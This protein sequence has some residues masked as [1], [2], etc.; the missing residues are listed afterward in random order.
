[1]HGPK[2]V[3]IVFATMTVFLS[4]LPVLVSSYQF[5]LL[6]LSFRA[7][8][9]EDSSLH[10]P[11]VSILIPAWNEGAVIGATIDRLMRL[12]YPRDRLRVYVI[13][14]A[15]TD[16]T[17]HVAIAKSKL[18]PRNVFHIRR[19]A[20]GEGKAHT[21]NYGL[22]VLW[23]SAWTEAVLIMDADVIYTEDS[24]TKMARHLVDPE[25]GAVTAYIKEGSREPNYVQR[26]ITFEYITA[27]GASRRAQNVLGFLACLSGG[28]QLHS[29]ENLLAIGGQIFSDT[30]AEDT[31]TTFRTQL[32]G[33]RAVFEPNAIVY[34]EEPDSLWML[35]KQ[36]LRW[37]RGNV[38]ITQVFW[39]LWFNG[40]LHPTMGSWAMGL[41]WFSIFLM[42]VF[43]IT[44]ALALVVLYFVDD[45][46]SW[47]LFR[48]YWILA[49]MVYLFVTMSSLAIDWESGRKSWGEGILFPGLISLL[50]IV[51][52]LV[53][54]LLGPLVDIVIGDSESIRKV[55]VLFLYMWLALSMLMSYGALV[56]E[57]TPS[58]AFLAPF[59]LLLGGYGSLLCAVTLGAYVKELSGAS[60]SWDKTVKTGKVG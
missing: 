54:S 26:Y 23:R 57:K 20:G 15:S 49:T 31:F 22:H 28:A 3:L 33:R 56:L 55:G 25:I 17:P 7:T 45:S 32:K 39:D 47:T 46:F 11:R 59:A 51:Y 50:I 8:H 14:D 27:T 42:P 21:L 52:S 10:L 41:L 48:G 53:P 12:R 30:L 40:K 36:R 4:S 9:L 29:R 19:V 60:R 35:W 37:A 2:L 34:A 18:W 43:Q 5:L 58:L 38:Q 16:E 44:G 6:L 24:L 13:D 1:M